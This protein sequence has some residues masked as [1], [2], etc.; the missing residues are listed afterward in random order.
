MRGLERD[1]NGLSRRDRRP[2]N[3][4]GHS[5]SRPSRRQERITRP[6]SGSQPGE[7]PAGTA[8]TVFSRARPVSK[9]CWRRSDRDGASVA[10][11]RGDGLVVE[12]H[13]ALG[14]VAEPQRA[15]SPDGH[16]GAARA[17]RAPPQWVGERIPVVEVAHDR[18]GTTGPVGRQGEGDTYHA[19]TLRLGC[20]DQNL[21]PFWR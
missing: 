20:L 5:Y 18:H 12:P 19:I 14:E 21:T 9:P 13:P 1:S 6:Q 2:G 15:A 3:V 16:R 7:E 8:R 10:V 4:P 17:V 11:K